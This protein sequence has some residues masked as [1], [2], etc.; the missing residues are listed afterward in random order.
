[1]LLW[2]EKLSHY[3]IASSSHSLR[4]L[5]IYLVVALVTF[6]GLSFLGLWFNGRDVTWG[7]NGQKD[8]IA[9]IVGA[10]LILAVM[11]LIAIFVLTYGYLSTHLKWIA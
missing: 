4:L 11:W 3:L 10:A 7:E 2:Q 8:R 5:E 6:F 1:M 9:S